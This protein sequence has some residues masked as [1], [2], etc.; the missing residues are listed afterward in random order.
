MFSRIFKP[1]VIFSLIFAL[2]SPVFAESVREKLSN[3]S[4]IEK[5]IQRG[6]L[7]VGFST[8]VPWAMKAKDGEFI[9][10]EIDVAKKLAND[11]GVKVE[12]IPTKWSGII[13]ALLTGK[14]DVIIGGMSIT[15]KR[16]L[17]VNFTIPYEYSG[18]S[19]VASKIN[20]KGMDEISDFNKEDMIIAARLG[21]TAEVAARKYLPKAKLKL[22]DSES[23]AV[24]EVLVGRAHA[25]VAS[26]PLPHFQAIKYPDRLYVPID[27]NF[28]KEPIA[29]AV[30]KGD[31]DT[32]NVF[33]SWIRLNWDS[34]WLKER[35]EYWF[36]TRKWEERIK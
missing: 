17:K 36:E 2:T 25:M 31:I 7:K 32:L 28:T 35:Y 34:G 13:P 16:N 23:Q 8:F 5:V 11:L 1:L 14:Y 4:T 26:A 10:F 3:E 30:K 33:N 6:V 12:F 19:I 18:M 21:T 9:G 20:A 15:P 29:F 27:E 22:F 24:Q